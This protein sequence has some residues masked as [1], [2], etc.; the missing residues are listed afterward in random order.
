MIKIL[1]AI[2]FCQFLAR[3]DRIRIP[4]LQRDYA[5]GRKGA[6]ETEIRNGFLTALRDALER[7]VDDQ[8]SPLNLDFV[9]GSDETVP[10]E[11]F[12]PLDG[13]QRLTTLF[14]LHWLLAWRD[15]CQADFTERF[16]EGTHA[17]F[18]YRV[19]TSSTEFF[20][21]L[22]AHPPSKLAEDLPDLKGWITDQDWY[23]RYW[24]LDPTVQGVLEM[25]QA[26]H[27]YFAGRKPGELYARLTDE[28]HPAITFQL[29]DLGEFPLSDD[30]YI[31]M[32]ARGKPLTAFETFK[33]LYEQELSKQF[34]GETR[35][36]G[37]EK[38]SIADFVSRRMD[39]A[40]ADFFWAHREKDSAVYDDAVMNLF[41]MIV[42]ISRNPQSPAFVRDATILRDAAAPLTFSTFQ[43]NQWLDEDFTRMLISLMEVWSATDAFSNPVLADKRYFDDEKIFLRLI[44]DPTGL[45]AAEVV[46]FAGYTLF[47]QQHE[48][49]ID[50]VAFGEWMRVVHNLA[51]NSDIDR[52]ALLQG[53][54]RALRELLP[55]STQI[56]AHFASL[57]PKDRISGFT[58]QQVRE[59]SLK[60]GLIL[61]DSQWRSLIERAENHGYF[62]GQ[63][64]FLCDFSGVIEQWVPGGL[65]AWDAATHQRLRESF[66]DYL[67]KAEAMFTAHG[68]MNLGE[69]RWQRALLSFGDYLLEN[70]SN[71]SFLVNSPNDLSSWKRFLRGST[72]SSPTKRRLLKNLWDRLATVRPYPEQLDEVT[73]AATGLVPWI[74]AFVRTPYAMAYCLRGLIRWHSPTEIFLLSTSQ[75]NGAHAE[76]FTYCLEHTV[77]RP[78]QKN[79]TLNPL[80][81]GQYYAPKNKD[82][83]PYIRLNFHYQGHG[84]FF[85]IQFTNGRYFICINRDALDPFPELRTL[86]CASGGF[87]AQGEVVIKHPLPD[88]IENAVLELATLLAALPEKQP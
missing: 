12:S 42:L 77:V 47:I 49:A 76:L 71:Y 22:V 17:R 18:S 69:S 8:F 39:T 65:L 38:F 3:H 6:K 67:C 23:F 2:T 59:E 74:E 79:G 15:G 87:T 61:A 50:P 1:E 32:N 33:A 31:K 10:D 4:Q 27:E 7:P 70:A 56:L 43:K 81:V 64:E 46:L 72:P 21:S 25:L 35:S 37:S 34:A 88:A 68:L 58:E 63:I 41:R 36:I 78:M 85:W 51:V 48:S 83:A 5:Q 29:L 55:K 44:S 30:L 14:L 57:G 52:T 28:Q 66:E 53:A 9:Y 19:R 16:Y 40:W 82:E 62:R 80:K 84:L 11:H 60:A 45:T 24:R 75:M 20:D 73:A 86:L 54:F 13:Q 26:M